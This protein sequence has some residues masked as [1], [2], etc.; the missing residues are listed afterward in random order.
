MMKPPFLLALVVCSVV[1][2]NLRMV[3]K[4]NSGKLLANSTWSKMC[5]F[6]EHPENICALNYEYL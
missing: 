1:S 6:C 3:S 5:S 4:R 2:T